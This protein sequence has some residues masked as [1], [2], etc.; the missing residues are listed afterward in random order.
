MR[1]KSLHLAEDSGLRFRVAARKKGVFSGQYA[2][3]LEE[4]TFSTESVDCCPS[5]Q[6]AVGQKQ[7]LEGIDENSVTPLLLIDALS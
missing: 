1:L 7:P 3:S 2:D 6:A 5:Q 4:P